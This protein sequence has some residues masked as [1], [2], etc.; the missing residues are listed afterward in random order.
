MKQYRA[1]LLAIAIFSMCCTY[2]LAE[3]DNSNPPFI[4]MPKQPAP[5]GADY[6]QWLGEW[7]NT[8]NNTNSTTRLVISYS[9]KKYF[10]HGYGKCHPHDC[11]WGKTELLPC[12][13]NEQPQKITAFA[14][15]DFKFKDH[16][17]I[18]HIKDDKLIVESIHIYKDNSKRKNLTQVETFTLSTKE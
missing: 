2:T 11:D 7:T 14:S 16:H 17:I 5:K 10:I 9:N 6:P 18:T 1:A 4:S 12:V 8:N 3:K 13:D 15:W